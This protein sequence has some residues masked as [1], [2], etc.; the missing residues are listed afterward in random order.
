MI[1]R[2][3]LFFI[4]IFFF[5]NLINA[6]V[7]VEGEWSNY[8]ESPFSKIYTNWEGKSV[9]ELASSQIYIYVDYKQGKSSNK[10]DLLF[11]GVADL[12]AGGIR[13]NIPW[14]SLDKN[15]PIGSF[16]K[17]DSKEAKLNWYGFLDNEGNKVDV[18]S[19]FSMSEINILER[20]R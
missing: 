5:S 3:S 11:L 13:L 2:N 10:I 6:E 17:I 16:E 14:K 9:I 12:G 19:D 15:S 1:L 4:T 20:C 7:K 18:M 8:C